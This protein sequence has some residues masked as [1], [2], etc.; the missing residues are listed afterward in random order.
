MTERGRGASIESSVSPEAADAVLRVVNSSLYNLY[1]RAQEI[2]NAEQRPGYAA[3]AEIAARVG[4]VPLANLQVS[5]PQ[6][7]EKTEQRPQMGS[8]KVPELASQFVSPNVQM[9]STKAAERELLAAG[10]DD[11]MAAMAA[12]AREAVY[13][14]HAQQGA[15]TA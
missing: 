14:A 13:T 10:E 7:V 2:I 15:R 12:R 5:Q 9:P 1:V 8:A 3:V 4:V 11:S 6:V